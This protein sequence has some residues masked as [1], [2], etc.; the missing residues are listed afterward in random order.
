VGSFVLLDQLGMTPNSRSPNRLVRRSSRFIRSTSFVVLARQMLV[1]V[2][3][4]L[5]REDRFGVVLLDWPAGLI[6]S[7][8]G[9][10]LEA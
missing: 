2:P 8:R 7:S 9:V 10:E 6:A 4:R 5:E 3:S 1:W